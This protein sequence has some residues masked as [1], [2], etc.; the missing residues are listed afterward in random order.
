VATSLAAAGL[1][2]RDG[3]SCALADGGEQFAAAL[4]RV[5]RDGAPSLGQAGRRLAVERYSIE[6]LTGLLAPGA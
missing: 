3:E 5:L 4:V 1:D 2:V 6:A